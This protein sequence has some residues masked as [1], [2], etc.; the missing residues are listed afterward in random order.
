MFSAETNSHILICHIW[1][2]FSKFDYPIWF[3]PGKF[4]ATKNKMEKN[5]NLI[6]SDQ[7]TK[8]LIKTRFWSTFTCFDQIFPFFFWMEKNWSKKNP[9]EQKPS[10]EGKPERLSPFLFGGLWAEYFKYTLPPRVCVH[11]KKNKVQEKDWN[12]F[13]FSLVGLWVEGIKIWDPY[14]MDFFLSPKTLFVSKKNLKPAH[15]ILW[16]FVSWRDQNLRPLLHGFFPPQRNH[17]F[18]HV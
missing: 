1:I 15:L 7:T 3:F 13:I 10:L 5:K 16:G 4:F 2:C 8:N 12:L 17:R 14:S 6:K 9:S 18:E 11:Q